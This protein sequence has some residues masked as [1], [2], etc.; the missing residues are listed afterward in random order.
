MAAGA[1]AEGGQ[2]RAR[3]QTILGMREEACLNV[4]QRQDLSLCSLKEE[5]YEMQKLLVRVAQLIMFS[6]AQFVS[7]FCLFLF[8]VPLKAVYSVLP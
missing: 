8:P 2:H 1:W 6:V 5:D 7:E 4:D 3:R